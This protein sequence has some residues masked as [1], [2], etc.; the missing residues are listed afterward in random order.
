MPTTSLRPDE[1]FVVSALK[2]AGA[3]AYFDDEEQM[4][5]AHHPAV[6]EAQAL[7]GYHI[8]IDW[9]SRKLEWP[10]HNPA[11]LTATAWIPDGR[12]DFHKVGTVYRSPAWASFAD[13]ATKCAL[14]SFQFLTRPEHT[15]DPA[16]KRHRRP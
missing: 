7:D 4:I 8:T 1:A 6:A 16:D 11:E 2:A 15:A 14:A 9:M 12:P 10:F 3:A 5:V 13:E